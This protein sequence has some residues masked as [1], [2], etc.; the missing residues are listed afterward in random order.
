MNPYGYSAPTNF[1]MPMS[2]NMC[3]GKGFMMDAYGC[4]QPCQC[5]RRIGCNI[6]HG[7][8]YF[9]NMNSIQQ[10]CQCSTMPGTVINVNKHHRNL[11]QYVGDKFRAIFGCNRCHGNGWVYS[12]YGNQTYC[13]NCI[14]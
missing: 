7:S 1:N 13:Q 8:G 2:C 3:M 9:M 10:P 6:C 11:F 12:K 14:R 5:K 4:Q